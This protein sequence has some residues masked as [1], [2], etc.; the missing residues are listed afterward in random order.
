MIRMQRVVH[1]FLR[2]TVNE[3]VALAGVD[4]H[5]RPQEFVTIIGSNGAGKSTLLRALAGVVMVDAGKIEVA[6]TDVTC[7]LEHRRAAFISRIDQNPLASTAPQLS[8]EENMSLALLRGQKRGL[9]LAVTRKRKDYFRAAL[10]K[11]ELGLEDRL[12]T[13]VGTLSGGQR[14]ALALVMAILAEP[15]VLLL[16]EH[17][18][19]LDPKAAAQVMAITER[20]VAEQRLTTLMVTHN[21]EHAIR[22]GTRLLMMHQGRIVV[23]V[24]GP[25]KAS[26][27]VAGLVEK[28]H[29]LSGGVLADET[30]LGDWETS[31]QPV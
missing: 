9:G 2:G 25:E 30:L 6:G 23:D 11:V 10:E 24:S 8:I 22:Y 12:T 15:K 20:V 17:A 1:H 28:F 31:G 27:T 19:A 16:D 7:W 4:L 14:Q 13:K 3:V 21:M 29:T 5:V 18:A 26:L